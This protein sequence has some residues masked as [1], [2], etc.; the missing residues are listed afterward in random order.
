MQHIE[1]L[2]AELCCKPE[3]LAV[4]SGLDIENNTV[5]LSIWRAFTMNTGR[6]HDPFK[7]RCLP[8]DH[9]FPK[10]KYKPVGALEWLLP[11]G[12]LKTGWMRKH[13]EEIPAVVAVF[14]DLDWSDNQWEEKSTECAQRVETVR[15][16]LAGRDCKLV[17]V[18]IQKRAPLPSGEDPIAME[19]AQALCTKCDLPGK[20]LFVL[21]HTNHLCGCVTSLESEFRDMA[22]SYY[23]LRAKKVKTHKDSLN[24]TSHQLLFIRHEFKIAFFGELKQDQALALKHYQQAYTHLLEQRIVD[25][26]LLEMKTVAGFINYKICRLAFQ[27]NASD[28]ISQFRR[29]IEFFSNLVGMPQLAFEHEA[30]MS[31]QYEILGDLFQEAIQSS[32]TALMTQH[33]GLYYQEAARHAIA[34]RQLC[35][36][37]CSHSYAV[38]TDPDPIQ[39]EPASF[40]DDLVVP[41]TSPIDSHPLSDQGLVSSVGV[42][43]VKTKRKN[44]SAIESVRPNSPLRF[45]RRSAGSSPASPVG[46]SPPLIP[47]SMDVYNLVSATEKVDGLE[48]YGQRPWRQ[49]VQSIEPPSA[50]KE[51]EG[52]RALQR[53]EL[54]VDHS[55][56]IIPLL[57]Q[58]H[59]HY[60]RYKAER[61]KLYPGK[62]CP[63][64]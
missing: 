56:R 9:Q 42:G 14:Y 59:L 40:T 64:F 54:A 24:K 47:L 61:M 27:N 51:R 52:I 53:A 34:R 35:R 12:I 7:F 8:V 45:A 16:K 23:H 20:N 43:A 50:T 39:E 57:E 31:K 63:I 46:R 41:Q 28:A 6:E 38:P 21:S 18:L 48:F 25:S 60:K 55:E 49:G 11:K 5:H 62:F 36:A 30:W 3:P 4:L 29:H 19:R 2:P 44:F 13:L 58:T 22:L 17:V 15:S 33:P 32:L 37:L 1:N 10:P 26:H